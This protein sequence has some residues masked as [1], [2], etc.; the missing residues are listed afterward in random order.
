MFVTLCI[1]VSI[2]FYSLI[3]CY[4]CTISCYIFCIIFCIIYFVYILY[5]LLLY[6]LWNLLFS[7]LYFSVHCGM[8]ISFFSEFNQ[9]S[10][11]FLIMHFLLVLHLFCI[12]SNVSWRIFNLWVLHYSFPLLWKI[13]GGRIFIRCIVWVISLHF[14]F[15]ECFVALCLV[16]QCVR[17]VM[18]FLIEMH[19]ILSLQA[20]YCFFPGH[21]WLGGIIMCPLIFKF[22]FAY[23]MLNISSYFFIS[24]CIYLRSCH[25]LQHESLLRLPLSSPM[26]LFQSLL[27]SVLISNCWLFTIFT[28]LIGFLEVVVNH[29]QICH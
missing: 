19:S 27:Y 28:Y 29:I 11:L 3:H 16:F 1:F 15:I 13:L 5:Y 9:F 4:F 23:G 18:M 14:I 24:L 7:I 21:K 20:K 12:Y 8:M 6:F 17:V 26:Y 25:S 2:S 22:S 10:F